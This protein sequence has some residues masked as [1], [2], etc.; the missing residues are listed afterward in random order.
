MAGFPQSGRLGSIAPGALKGSNVDLA[1]DLTEMIEAQRV[2]TANGKSF[3]TSADLMDV[4]V[5]RQSNRA[6]L[7]ISPAG[8]IIS[9]EP[10][11][12]PHSREKHDLATIELCPKQPQR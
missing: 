1:H 8:S 6:A 12:F 11:A 3:Q 2:Y 7:S 10:A 5:N 4:L 9:S